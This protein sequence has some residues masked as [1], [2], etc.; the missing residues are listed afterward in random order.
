MPIQLPLSFDDVP[1][2]CPVQERYHAIA[3]CLAGAVSPTQRA[4]V[5]NISYATVTRWLRDF[6]ERGMPGLFHPTQFPR[7]PYTPERIV[8]LLIYFKCCAPK[9]SDRELA[10]V[11]TSTM[12]HRL[13]NETVR[14]LLDRYFFWRYPDF[15]DRVSYPVP[16]EPH[17]RRLE[18]VR[19]H[20]QGFTEKTIATL[21]A[22]SPR[23]VFKWLRRHREEGDQG[24]EEQ[25]RVRHTPSR[26]VYFGTIHA[27]LELQHK[28]GYAGA[29]RIKGYLER[30]YGI[31]VSE[32]TVK[33]VMRMNRRVHLAPSRPAPAVRDSREGPPVSHH[34]FQHTYIDIRYLDAKPEGV[35][36]YSTL[37]LEGLSRTILAGSLTRRQ[38][39]G[40][41][42]RLYYVALLEWGCWQEVISDHGSQFR[43]HAFVGANR[44]LGIAHTMYERGHPWQNLI[45]SQFG[46]Q[47]RLGE[48]GWERCRSV[49][50]AV[51]FHRELIRDH[52]RLPHFAH[53]LRGDGKHAPLE[54]LGTA[55]GRQVEAADLHR[56]FSRKTWKRMTDAR[57][58]IRVN[59]WKIY[60]EQGLPRVPL[61][62]S[63]WDG[64]LRA[65]YESQ[66]VAEY[67]CRWD[68][69]LQRPKAITSPTLY[70]TAY[71]SRQVELF[72]PLWVRDPIETEPAPRAAARLA[73]GGHQLRLYLGPALVP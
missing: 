20:D 65:E 32:A 5:L 72:D 18:M 3:P 62:V 68:A 16:A 71:R 40:V 4:R 23:T 33:R 28:F 49:A 35:Q 7:E 37:L 64:V 52:N 42:L 15:R 50:A 55:R 14:D 17:A 43:S 34:P 63:F 70:E 44:R 58:F 53:R 12:G 21:L 38:D 46:I 30:D 36:L 10:R 22:C 47:A 11:V 69:H 25:S 56:A 59:R 1:V 66:L 8:V 45:E 51:E 13:H 29:F 39:L 26:K 73:A 19:L 27:T 57:G 2:T 6:R 41:V 24:V 67:R 61:Q 54:V 31:V 60:V 9:A 48:Y